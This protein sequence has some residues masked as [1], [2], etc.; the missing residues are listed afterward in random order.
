MAI[1]SPS[2]EEGIEAVWFEVDASQVPQL[3]GAPTLIDL[4]DRLSESSS[5]K[6]QAVVVVV[7]VAVV[8]VVVAVRSS[9]CGTDCERQCRELCNL[10]LK[11]R[12]VLEFSTTGV[13]SQ[14]LMD[15]EAVSSSSQQCQNPRDSF[16]IVVRTRLG[17]SEMYLQSQCMLRNFV[18][19][20]RPTHI[21]MEKSFFTRVSNAAI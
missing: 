9:V 21:L 14:I 8:V 6:F 4:P 13:F 1:G 20:L 11:D 12:L 15:V 17:L 5:H 2:E 3:G 10:K 19:N 7:G 16:L 18:N